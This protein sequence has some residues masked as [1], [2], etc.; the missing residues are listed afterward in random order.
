MAL[1]EVRRRGTKDRG[2][3]TVNGRDIGGRERGQSMSC[4]DPFIGT[5]ICTLLV[6]L[7]YLVNNAGLPKDRESQLY[8]T[9][10]LAPAP[11]VILFI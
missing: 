9:Y 2:C 7:L 10:I 11:L 3:F 8:N 4:S 5:V 6:L 1:T